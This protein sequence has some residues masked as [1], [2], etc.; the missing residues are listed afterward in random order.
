MGLIS[1]DHI[2]PLIDW[3]DVPGPLGR[4]VTDV[5]VLLGE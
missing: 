1:R 3:M 2:I 4:T 5:A